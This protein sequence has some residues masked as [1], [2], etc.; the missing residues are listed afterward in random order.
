MIK[1]ENEVE[2]LSYNVLSKINEVFYSH[3][4]SRGYFIIIEN[5][6]D[7][8]EIS[9]TQLHRYLRH[10]SK[11]RMILEEAGLEILTGKDFDVFANHCIYDHRASRVTKFTFESLIMLCLIHEKNHIAKLVKDLVLQK[12]YELLYKRYQDYNSM[13]AYNT[14]LPLQHNYIESMNED[15]FVELLCSSLKKMEYKVL[16]RKHSNEFGADITFI[17]NNNKRKVVVQ[18]KHTE[19]PEKKCG[20]RA[21]QEVVSGKLY[22]DADDAMVICNHNNFSRNA[23]LLAKKLNIR[24]LNGQDLIHFIDNGFFM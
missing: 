4:P 6:A 11:R 13:A 15:N 1:I 14:D 9:K 7:F 23:K 24:L 20:I 8:L 21:V 3:I 19:T 5:V 18:V 10:G 22:Y 12:E 17:K 2:K 16:P